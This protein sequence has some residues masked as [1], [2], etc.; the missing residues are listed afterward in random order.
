VRRSRQRGQCRVCISPCSG[1]RSAFF[2]REQGSALDISVG[3]VLV[4]ALA[5]GDDKRRPDSATVTTR[6]EFSFRHH[7]LP[8]PPFSLLDKSR[9]SPHTYFAGE[10]D[11]LP[12]QV[13]PGRTEEGMNGRTLGGDRD[14]F[15][16][17]QPNHGGMP[18]RKADWRNAN[19]YR[20]NCHSNRDGE[21]RGQPGGNGAGKPGE[22]GAVRRKGSQQKE[23]RK[24]ILTGPKPGR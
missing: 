2:S 23:V 8:F 11:Q 18:I 12:T 6:T 24:P 17:S 22:L 5:L 4:R 3:R 9:T 1:S 21:H 20:P 14:S 13:C 19:G 7:A 16:G 15:D 10:L